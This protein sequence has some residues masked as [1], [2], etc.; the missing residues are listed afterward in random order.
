MEESAAPL[1]ELRTYIDSLNALQQ[2]EEEPAYSIE[3]NYIKF[4]DGI[5]EVGV[6]ADGIL[7][8]TIA[9]VN[10]EQGLTALF[11]K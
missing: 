6:S 4:S 8:V 7:K 1:E 2:A 3:Y 5:E 11:T 10:G 9:D